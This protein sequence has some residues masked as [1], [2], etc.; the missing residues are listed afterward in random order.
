MSTKY[1]SKC[2]L[3]KTYRF[4]R[5]CCVFETAAKITIL[6]VTRK[7]LDSFSNIQDTLTK[8][9]DYEAAWKV[10]RGINQYSQILGTDQR[11]SDDK[12]EDARAKIYDITWISSKKEY[13][14]KIIN[15]HFDHFFMSDYL[16]EMWTT[17]CSLKNKFSCFFS[18]FF[19]VLNIDDRAKCRKTQIYDELSFL[20]SI[21]TTQAHFW[22]KF[23]TSQAFI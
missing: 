3:K 10:E 2:L 20:S 15:F 18:S 23:R 8:T 16:R 13:K 21:F 11:E 7:P 1:K 22:W 6:W 19:P 5:S 9:A 4:H 12:K 17:I 14:M